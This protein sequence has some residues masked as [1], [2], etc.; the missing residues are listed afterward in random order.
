MA[1]DVPTVRIT[2]TI[3]AP[4]DRVFKAWT[5]PAL[6]H[7]WLA[8]HPCEVREA[9]ADARAGGRYS[10]VVVDLANGD[11]HT[12]T[13]EYLEV[14]PG[15]R[16]V[17]TWTYDGPHGADLV[18]SMLT[19]DF[20]E[21]RPGVTE[22]TLTHSSLRDDHATRMVSGGWTLCLDKLAGLFNSGGNGA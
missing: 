14:A 5:D 13:G 16:I 22:L 17:K 7:R 9:I 11:V 12:T 18:P 19:V 21:V 10:I 20:R 2:R 15:R 3:D 8:P 1:P 4:V 6:M